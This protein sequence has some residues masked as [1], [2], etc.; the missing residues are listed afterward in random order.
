M[1]CV[2]S[3]YRNLWSWRHNEHVIWT[4]KCILHSIASS[5]HAFVGRGS[6]VLNLANSLSHIF[7]CT[8]CVCLEN[9][10]WFLSLGPIFRPDL[11]SDAAQDWSRAC[12]TLKELWNPSYRFAQ[13]IFDCRST[14]RRSSQ[15]QS[16]SQ[17]SQSLVYCFSYFY[18]FYF[19]SFNSFFP[20][21]LI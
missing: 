15:N 6:C 12:V 21:H 13:S 16:Q 18:F 2:S 14:E 8:A 19:H 7:E 20:R 11:R 4:P 9:C 3:I 10:L 5:P 1:L 17:S